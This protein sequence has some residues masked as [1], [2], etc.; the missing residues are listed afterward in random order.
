M[1]RI[2]LITERGRAI[3]G[4]QQGAVEV[5]EFG[6][7][8]E[9][10]RGRHG[11]RRRN[12]AADHQ[13]QSERPRLASERYGFGEPARLVELHIDMAVAP[14]KA[15]QVGAR[16]AALDR[17]STRLNSSHTDISRMPSSA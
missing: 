11:E 12:H 6:E 1:Q 2:A 3:L 15:R 14:E 5:D 13:L 10:G 17:K 9:Q 7:P 4:E 16:M 8:G